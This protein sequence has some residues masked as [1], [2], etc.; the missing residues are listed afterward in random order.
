MVMKL[1]DMGLLEK[2]NVLEGLI[3]RT[4]LETEYSIDVE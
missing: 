1:E 4:E 3:A 2:V